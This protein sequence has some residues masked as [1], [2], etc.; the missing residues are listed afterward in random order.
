[1][2]NQGLYEAVSDTENP[3]DNTDDIT[4]EL[5]DPDSNPLLI[6]PPPPPG[7]VDQS[8]I[9]TLAAEL[10]HYKENNN[11]LER[12]LTVSNAKILHLENEAATG[13]DNN[14]ML[15][16]FTLSWS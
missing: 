3:E 15:T 11:K 8:T 1:M 2:L 6:V 16:R 14:L 9:D 10:N 5:D 13:N 4:V 7:Q 12:Q